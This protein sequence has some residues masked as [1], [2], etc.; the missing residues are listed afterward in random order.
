MTCLTGDTFNPA[1][2]A[3][4]ISSGIPAAIQ[5]RSTLYSAKPRHETFPAF[6]RDLLCGLA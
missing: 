3:S 4:S 1:T 6:V 5:S 2:G